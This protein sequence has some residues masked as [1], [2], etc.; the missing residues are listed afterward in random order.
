MSISDVA[1]S[2]MVGRRGG[3]GVI[4]GGWPGGAAGGQTAWMDWVDRAVA[5]ARDHTPVVVEIAD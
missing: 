5:G 1:L 3:C 4:P 2:A